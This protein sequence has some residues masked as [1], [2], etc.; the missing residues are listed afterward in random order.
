[1]EEKIVH[2]TDVQPDHFLGSCQVCLDET[3]PGVG[4]AAV[5]GVP[6]SLVWCARCLSVPAVPLW[7]IDFFVGE[8]IILPE[9]DQE[10]TWDSV[11]DWVRE[12]VVWDK[13]FRDYRK[14]IELKL[15][16]KACPNCRGDWSHAEQGMPMSIAGVD[17]ESACPMCFM[18][19]LVQTDG[20]LPS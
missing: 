2:P 11:A 19:Q 7:I 10:L 6:L 20:F 9:K 15:V 13:N 4:I 16:V 5:P 3:Q 18:G 12:C 1:M 17:Y 14:V 8:C